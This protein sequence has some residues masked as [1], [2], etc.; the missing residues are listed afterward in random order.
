MDNLLMWAFSMA[1]SVSFLMG[2]DCITVITI[3][4]VTVL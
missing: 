2:F 1:P 3:I 4:I